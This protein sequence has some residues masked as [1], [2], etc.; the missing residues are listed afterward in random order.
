MGGYSSCYVPGMVRDNNIKRS[1]AR[2]KHRLVQWLQN[3][4]G[5]DA[6]FNR[7]TYYL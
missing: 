7:Y 2:L 6:V 1:L 3:S 4:A 5:A